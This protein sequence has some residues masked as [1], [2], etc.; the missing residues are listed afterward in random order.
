M[1]FI[2]NWCPV[3]ILSQQLTL[4]ENGYGCSFVAKLT[5]KKNSFEKTFVFFTKYT[6]FAEKMFL[7]ERKV[8]QWKIFL[9]Q[10]TFFCREKYK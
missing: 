5:C 10:K 9:M 1:D 8:L 3:L 2:F 7:Y 6:L 4:E